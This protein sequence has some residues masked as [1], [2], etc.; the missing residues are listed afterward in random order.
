MSF[1]RALGI[2][3]KQDLV[4][5]DKYRARE[6]AAFQAEMATLNGDK[7]LSIPKLKDSNGWH[8]ALGK[9]WASSQM[10]GIILAIAPQAAQVVLDFAGLS[11]ASSG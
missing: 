8:R 10:G 4:G 7:S 9:D 5:F 2:V 1:E 11:Y 6:R 3:A